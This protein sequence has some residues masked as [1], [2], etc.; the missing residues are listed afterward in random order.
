LAATHYKKGKYVEL[1]EHLNTISRDFIFLIKTLDEMCNCVNSIFHDL[2]PKYVPSINNSTNRYP[3]WY[4]NQLIY[5][6]NKKSITGV[7]RVALN[8]KN[9]LKSIN[10]SQD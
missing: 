1:N 3:P 8:Q 9:F 6:I 5:L 7:Q 10:I 2:L 4:S